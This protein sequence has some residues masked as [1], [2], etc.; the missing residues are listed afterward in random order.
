MSLHSGFVRSIRLSFHCLGHFLMVFS[1]VIALVS[2][3]NSSNQT[4]ILTPYCEVKPG[5]ARSGVRKAW[6]ANPSSRRYRVCRC[7][8]TPIYRRS[9]SC[10]RRCI[11]SRCF[12]RENAHLLIPVL[13]TG[14]QP[15]QVLGLSGLSRR[16]DARRLDSCDKHRDEESMLVTPAPA[17]THHANLKNT[18]E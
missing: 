16:A 12:T 4:S 9:P 14:I 2:R 11:L 15:A 17:L 8:W 18:M 13:V 10:G 1:R 7:V 3:S 6:S 5:V